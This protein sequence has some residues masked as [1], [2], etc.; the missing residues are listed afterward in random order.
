H[1]IVEESG[2]TFAKA[3]GA[4]AAGAPAAQAAAAPS[5][6]TLLERFALEPDE[7]EAIKATL[8]TGASVW[9]LE[10]DFQPDSPWL[11]VRAFQALND[12]SN[13]GELLKSQPTAEDVEAERVGSKLLVVIAGSEDAAES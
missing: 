6:G 2:G 5:E 8:D 10:V 3:P 12:L 4:A 7:I 11:A 1:A 13:V 9:L